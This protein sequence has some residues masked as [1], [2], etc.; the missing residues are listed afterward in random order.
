MKNSFQLCGFF[1]VVFVWLLLCNFADLCCHHQLLLTVCFSLAG[2]L[3]FCIQSYFSLDAKGYLIVEVNAVCQLDTNYSH[4][5][6]ESQL[7]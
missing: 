6:R 2:V 1:C 3:H 7:R 5:E 4:L